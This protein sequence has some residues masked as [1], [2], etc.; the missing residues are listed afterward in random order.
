MKNRNKE[1]INNTRFIRS[2]GSYWKSKKYTYLIG[3]SFSERR[4]ILSED[5]SLIR[6]NKLV[7]RLIANA[8]FKYSLASINYVDSELKGINKDIIMNLGELGFIN[9]VINIMIV[10]PTGSGK[11]YL[12]GAL[13][14]ETCKIHIELPTLKCKI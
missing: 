14:V 5:I 13:R 7:P 6:Y 10:G 4:E 9:I 1:K 3:N 8:S 2:C 12:G 11:T